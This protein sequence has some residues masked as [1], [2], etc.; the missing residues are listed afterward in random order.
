MPRIEII[1]AKIFDQ[2]METEVL[3]SLIDEFL[4]LVFIFEILVLK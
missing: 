3:R 1:K 4:S 2:N